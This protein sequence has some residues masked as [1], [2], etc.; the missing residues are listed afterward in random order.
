V[1]FFSRARASEVISPAPA[2]LLVNLE[3]EVAMKSEALEED[4][5]DDSDL[6]AL[7][8]AALKSIKA[9]PLNYEVKA[10]PVRSNLLAIII[11]T[12]KTKKCRTTADAIHTDDSDDIISESG[13]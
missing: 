5:E 12:E 7:R 13:N 2:D 6:L 8:A 11:Q 10:H 3:N 1:S 9:K 4:E